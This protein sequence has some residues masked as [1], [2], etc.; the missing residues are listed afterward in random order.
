MYQTENA[1][2]FQIY[3]NVH[4]TIFSLLTSRNRTKDADA[5][6]AIKKSPFLFIFT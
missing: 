5:G 6:N 3:T 2:N 1:G 4:I